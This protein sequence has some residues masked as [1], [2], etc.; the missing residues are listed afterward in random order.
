MSAKLFTGSPSEIEFIPG[1]I[2]G[3]LSLA[4]AEKPE[5]GTLPMDKAVKTNPDIFAGLSH[6]ILV[7]DSSEF[8]R[9]WMEQVSPFQLRLNTSVITTS[10]SAPML[11]PYYASGQIKGYVAGLSDAKTLGVEKDLLVNQRAFQVGTLLMILV[12]LLG[13][14]MKLDEDSRSKAERSTE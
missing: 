8:V 12:L 11:S 2:L 7:S 10:L 3:Y 6:L 1:S 13:I 14:I 5:W 4:V 9:S